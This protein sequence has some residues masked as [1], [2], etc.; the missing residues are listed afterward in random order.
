MR[1]IKPRSP[2]VRRYHFLPRKHGWDMLLD[3]GRIETLKN[4]VRD[5]TPHQLSFYEILF[6][7]PPHH[8]HTLRPLSHLYASLSR[9]DKIPLI[10][11]GHLHRGSKDLFVVSSLSIA[12]FLIET[13]IV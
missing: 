3:I 12:G 7:E 9:S 11:S 8:F 1:K 4:F 6:L 2:V 10:F 13:A 5:S